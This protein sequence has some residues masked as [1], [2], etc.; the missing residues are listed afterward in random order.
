MER[1]LSL[2]TGKFGGWAATAL[3]AIVGAIGL[4]AKGRG[5]GKRIAKVD[6]YERSLKEVEK[7]NAA[8]DS[9]RSARHDTGRVRDE[10]FN[11]DNKRK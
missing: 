3:A 1:I 7:T 4:Y 11:R 10:R 6:E 8:I 5:D 9:A 2:F